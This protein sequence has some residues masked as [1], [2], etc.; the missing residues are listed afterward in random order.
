[1]F[2]KHCLATCVGLLLVVAWAQPARAQ[3][4]D[5]TQH[6]I[7]QVVKQQLIQLHNH[8]GVAAQP[9]QPLAPLPLWLT[10][11]L[12]NTPQQQFQDRCERSLWQRL[13]HSAV[14]GGDYYVGQVQ[15]DISLY[16]GA[17]VAAELTAKKFH[18]VTTWNNPP[19]CSRCCPLKLHD[20][21]QNHPDQALKLLHDPRAAKEWCDQGNDYGQQPLPALQPAGTFI[22]F[23]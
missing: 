5:R 23:Q 19:T 11:P 12:G 22:N 1:M 20:L 13:P 15:A 16:L 14:A 2:L 21:V 10:R 17:K 9:G 3:F 8:S 7:D 4:N 6:N 18:T